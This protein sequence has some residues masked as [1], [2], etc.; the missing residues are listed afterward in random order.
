MTA[1]VWTYPP[2]MLEALLGFGLAPTP[3]TE[4]RFVRDCLSDL[5]LY[6]IRCLRAHLLAGE[7][8]MTDYSRRVILLRDHYW[9]LK[10]TPQQWEKICTNG[11]TD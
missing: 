7:F 1:R 10:F 3:E 9:P 11:T 5:Y 8:P 6:E 4:P 2:E